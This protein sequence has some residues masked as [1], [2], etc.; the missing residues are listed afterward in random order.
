MGDWYSVGVLVGVGVALGVLLAG[1]LA[2]SRVGLLAAAA[3]AAGAALALGVALAGWDEAVGGAVGGLAGTAGAGQLA[4]GTLRGGGTR[5]GTA[6]LLGLGGLALAA[7][8][9]VPALGYIEAVAVPALAVR[10]RR[11]AGGRYAGLRILARD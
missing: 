11:R 6:V 4:Q 5:A 9:L 10:L 7:L 3:L 1:A 8:A 2:T